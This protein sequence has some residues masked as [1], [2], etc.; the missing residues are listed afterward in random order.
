V[1]AHVSP[2]DPAGADRPPGDDRDTAARGDEDRRQR[3]REAA[4]AAEFATGRQ[5]TS[6]AEARSSLIVRLA[7]IV[8]GFTVLGAG[9]VML[10]LPGPG[11]LAVLAGLGILSRE[12]PWAER[13][14]VYVKRRA[15]LDELKTQ[16]AWVRIAT[17]ALT[18][19]AVVG[20]MTYLLV[21]R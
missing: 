2:T 6:T 16:P 5:E 9:L 8:V 17:W 14:M 3:M 13:V 15:R 11:I 19:V 4:L 10:L 12:L 18:I 1:D 7:T 21:V 20:S